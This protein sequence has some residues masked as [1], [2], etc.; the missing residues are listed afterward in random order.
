MLCSPFRGSPRRWPCGDTRRA[1]GLPGVVGPDHRA[2]SCVATGVGV[3]AWLLTA[4]GDG[5]AE[6]TSRLEADWEI[7]LKQKEVDQAKVDPATRFRSGRPRRLR[8]MRSHDASRTS[9]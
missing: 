6:A 5:T 7:A 2:G 4:Y 9:P 3:A 8:P 1:R